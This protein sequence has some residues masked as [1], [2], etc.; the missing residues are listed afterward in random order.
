VPADGYGDLI[1][2]WVNPTSL[3]GGVL[4]VATCIFLAGVFLTADAARAGETALGQRLRLQTLAVGAGTASSCSPGCI[5][6]PTM[7]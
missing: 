2:S 3:V 7:L 5:R 6:S 1:G 4:A